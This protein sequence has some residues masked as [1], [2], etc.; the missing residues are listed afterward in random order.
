MLALVSDWEKIVRSPKC[1]IKED[2][3]A[4]LYISSTN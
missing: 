3:Q 1:K 4:W 2:P